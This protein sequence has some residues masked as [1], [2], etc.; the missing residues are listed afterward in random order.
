LWGFAKVRYR[1]LQKDTVRVLTLFALANLY[2]VRLPRGEQ[3]AF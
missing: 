3:F 1:G 2:L